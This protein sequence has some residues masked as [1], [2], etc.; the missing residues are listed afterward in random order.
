[1][2]TAM[3]EEI[4]RII[5]LEMGADDYVPKPFNPREL[6]ARIRAVLRRAGAAASVGARARVLDFSGWRID[7]VMREFR[8]PHGTRIAVTGAEFGCSRCC[9]SGR[10]GAVAR[11]T[12]R[13][14]AGRSAGSLE[15][16]IDVLISRLRRKIERDPHDPEIIKT[17]RSGGYLFTPTVEAHEFG[18]RSLS[19]EPHQRP[20]RDRHRRVADCD[21][22]GADGLVLSYCPQRPGVGSVAATARHARRT[23]RRQLRR[24]RGLGWSPRWQWGFPRLE[25][26]LTRI[27]AAERRPALFADTGPGSVC[28]HRWSQPIFSV[29]ESSAPAWPGPDLIAI[30]LKDGTFVY[31]TVAAHAVTAASQPHHHH[32]L[33][34]SISVT[35][36]GV[37]AARGLTGPLRRFAGGGNFTPDGD[38]AP[39]PE[40]GPMKSAPRRVPSIRCANGSRAWSRTAPACWRPSATIADADHAAAAACE[41]IEDQPRARRCSTSSP[42]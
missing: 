29:A 41:F 28:A 13:S 39:L 30:A 3:G 10:T 16:S 15:R 18:I 12:T 24:I 14:D 25:M 36:L 26:A 5:G 17:V 34:L 31:G 22:Y 37:W 20:D 33:A 6:L 19:A 11:A 40:R 8:D 21:P 38:L 32:A 23:D 27:G 7:C 4:D 1:M 35:L 9:A 2:L 42:I